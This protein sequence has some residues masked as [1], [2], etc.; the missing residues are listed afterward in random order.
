MAVRI[1][2][3]IRNCRAKEGSD[4]EKSIRQFHFEIFAYPDFGRP[5]MQVYKVSDNISRQTITP[6]ASFAVE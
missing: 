3:Y 1:Q 5:M 6:S 4:S 2:N